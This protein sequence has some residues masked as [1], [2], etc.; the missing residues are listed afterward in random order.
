M[1]SPQHVESFATL[2]KCSKITSVHENWNIY[3]NG[4]KQ[5]SL[6]LFLQVVW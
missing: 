6:L 3:S 5:T 1:Q 4:E 2:F